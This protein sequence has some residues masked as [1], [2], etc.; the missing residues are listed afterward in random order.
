MMTDRARLNLQTVLWM[1]YLLTLCCTEMNSPR[2]LT[3][4]TR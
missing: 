2:A 4:F 1:S 3:K